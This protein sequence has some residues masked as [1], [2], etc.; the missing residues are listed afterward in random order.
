MNLHHLRGMS[1]A[2]ERHFNLEQWF[3]CALRMKKIKNISQ[4]QKDSQ[5]IKSDLNKEMSWRKME[6]THQDYLESSL[7]FITQSTSKRNSYHSKR[8]LKKE[9][10]INRSIGEVMKKKEKNCS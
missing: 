1:L 2:I 7:R 5:K 4:L 9:T 8:N 6:T 10:N 3:I